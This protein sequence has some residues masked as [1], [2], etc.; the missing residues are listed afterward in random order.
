[1]LRGSNLCVRNADKFSISDEGAMAVASSG[2]LQRRAQGVAADQGG[3]KS[4][5]PGWLQQAGEN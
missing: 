2:E 4:L 5:G 1:M 3:D